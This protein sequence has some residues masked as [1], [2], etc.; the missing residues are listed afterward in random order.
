MQLPLFKLEPTNLTQNYG[1]TESF[2]LRLLEN[3]NTHTVPERNKIGA[4]LCAKHQPQHIKR[5]C[6]I[7]HKATGWFC[8]TAAAG[9]R[10]SRAPGQCQ[11]A[12][13]SVLKTQPQAQGNR[14]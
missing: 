14:S 13:K 9:L 2:R 8:K 5:L 12:P 4:R 1:S 6:G 11:D 7:G 10:H 3:G